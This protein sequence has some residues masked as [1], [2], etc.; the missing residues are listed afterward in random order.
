VFG[1]SIVI[2]DT[3]RDAEIYGV[4]PREN[5]LTFS[6]SPPENMLNRLKTPEIE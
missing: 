6:I 5:M 3:I 4:I 2:R 1:S